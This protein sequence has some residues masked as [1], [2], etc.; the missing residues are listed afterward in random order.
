MLLG[1]KGT[2]EKGGR[3]INEIVKTDVCPHKKK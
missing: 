3:S 1:F 2:R